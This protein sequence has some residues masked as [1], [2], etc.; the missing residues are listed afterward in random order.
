MPAFSQVPDWRAGLGVGD[1]CEVRRPGDEESPRAY[2]FQGRV[3]GRR[4]PEIDVR[5][6]AVAGA[7]GFQPVWTLAVSSERLA[8]QHEHIL[9]DLWQALL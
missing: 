9:P 3:T 7:V 8:A 1:G 6:Q 2:W 4:G 5:L